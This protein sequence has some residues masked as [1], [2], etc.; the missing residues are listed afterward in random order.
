MKD[1]WMA[2]DEVRSIYDLPP[3]RAL[4]ELSEDA[5]RAWHVKYLTQEGAEPRIWV[6]LDKAETAL[7]ATGEETTIRTLWMA[8]ADKAAQESDRDMVA[9]AALAGI[10]MGLKAG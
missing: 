2:D 8:L 9:A 10:A 3:R 5:R 1:T 4:A 7:R 6:L